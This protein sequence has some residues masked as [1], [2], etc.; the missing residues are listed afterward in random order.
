MNLIKNNK[1]QIFVAMSGGVDSSVVAA[2]L[3]KQG[4]KVIGV[5]MKNWSGESMGI[6]Y[7]CPWEEDMLILEKVCDKL[8]IELRSYNFEKE[9]ESEVIN[10]FFEEYRKGRTPNPDVVCNSQIKFGS[11]LERAIEEGA[12]LIATGHYARIMQNSNEDFELHKGID[13]A[14][15]QSYFLHRLDQYQ[16]SKTL[17]PI[18]NFTKK[19]VREMAEEFGLQNAKRKDSQGICFVGKVNVRKLLEQTIKP[20]VGDIVDVDTGT[21]LGKHN[22]I[23]YYTI[24]QREGLGIGGSDKP[25][26]VSG[27]SLEKN[28]LFVAKGEDNPSLFTKRFAF[29]NMHSIIPNE[30]EPGMECQVSVRYRQEPQKAKLIKL[31]LNKAEGV[32]QCEFDAPVRGVAEG[33]SGVVYIKDR[34]LGGGVISKVLD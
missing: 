14:K 21:I 30:I 3:K 17:F 26:F 20:R 15:D 13:K 29:E 23:Y 2:I 4:H 1:K 27:K 31:D 8:K 28:I 18:G 10:Y 33:Q 16:L 25:Y 22:G 34:C 32:W 11:F 7:N 12:E 9:Y 6:E 19:I 24:G 5:Y